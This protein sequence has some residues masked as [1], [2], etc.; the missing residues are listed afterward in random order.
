[1]VMA[2][3]W[4][5][6]GQGLNPNTFGNLWPLL[7]IK[8][9]KK[10]LAR[11][12]KCLIWL[13]LKIMNTFLLIYGQIKNPMCSFDLGIN[14]TLQSES[15]KIIQTN[16]RPW[17]MYQWRAGHFFLLG[18]LQVFLARIWIFLMFF[19]PT[20]CQRSKLGLDPLTGQSLGEFPTEYH[21]LWEW[22]SKP[23][24]TLYTFHSVIFTEKARICKLNV[25]NCN[26]STF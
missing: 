5:S 20:V 16:R 14:L 19:L 4:A 10:I 17:C 22:T 8:C 12:K 9:T 6:E 7:A 18:A 25:A 3:C 26:S 13:I 15:L 11:I 2:S 24:F 21:T 1:M 23:F